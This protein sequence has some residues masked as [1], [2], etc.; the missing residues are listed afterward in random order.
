MRTGLHAT[1]S[2]QLL[3][4]APR[5]PW[6][7]VRLPTF[8]P[9]PPGCFAHCCPW[10][11]KLILLPMLRT[12][13]L[14]AAS[15]FT[16][17][18]EHGP[19]TCQRALAPQHVVNHRCL[20]CQVYT[21]LQGAEAAMD[22]ASREIFVARIFGKPYYLP[23]GFVLCCGGLR[24]ARRFPV[25]E[26]RALCSAVR[27]VARIQLSLHHLFEDGLS[28]SMADVLRE[29]FPPEL[30]PR[31]AEFSAN[32]VEVHLPGK[33]A[34]SCLICPYASTTRFGNAWGTIRQSTPV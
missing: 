23:R 22:A 31:L 24:A 28:Q 5:P 29:R 14:A 16:H 1:P 11:R 2:P 27:G 33:I 30:L 32:I 25:A 8:L 15:C 6:L 18:I 26:A 21:S 3:R 7:L 4:C 17:A 12:A 19:C 34:R 9:R 13:C 20:F 10:R